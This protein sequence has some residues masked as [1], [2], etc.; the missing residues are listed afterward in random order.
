MSQRRSANHDG[1]Q[2]P[3]L[4]VN[5]ETTHVVL[6]PAFQIA[7]A[8]AVLRKADY[9]GPIGRVIDRRQSTAQYVAVLPPLW[10]ERSLKTRN[11]AA[12]D[13]P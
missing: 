10:G 9:F 2:F 11:I 5:P 4:R 12:M 13:L 3:D 1:S 8:S 6:L 7:A